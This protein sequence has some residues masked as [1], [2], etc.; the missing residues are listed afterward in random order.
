MATPRAAGY[1]SSSDI[2][3]VAVRAELRTFLARKFAFIQRNLSQQRIPGERRIRRQAM[4]QPF[5][6]NP[7][8]GERHHYHRRR[9]IIFRKLK[10]G[11]IETRP[12]G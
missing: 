9:V 1:G 5:I 8:D 11:I 7:P 3:T 4:R 10:L 12:G 2:R 6:D